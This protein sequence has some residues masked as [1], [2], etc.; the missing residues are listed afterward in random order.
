MVELRSN[1]LIL[2]IDQVSFGR[3][4]QTVISQASIKNQTSVVKTA[5]SGS[6]QI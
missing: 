1:R 6:D 5:L 2:K 4:G 3:P